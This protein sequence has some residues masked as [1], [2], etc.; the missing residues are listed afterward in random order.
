MSPFIYNQ[1]LDFEAAVSAR[2]QQNLRDLQRES[3]FKRPELREKVL[4]FAQKWGLEPETV[5]SKVQ[6]DWLF[7]LQFV[8]DPIRQT[9]HQRLAAEFIKSNLQ[10]LVAD[11]AELPSGGAAAKWLISGMVM[12][13]ADYKRGGADKQA[14]TVDFEWRLP[15]ETA[16]GRSLRFY[17]SHKFT[18]DEGGTQN[19][20][21]E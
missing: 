3:T 2:R 9:L 8:K 21:Y 6:D 1:R 20:Q 13:Q 15:I 14:R 5:W 19:N 7:A 16:D 11:F 18:K 4:S 10:P 17:A 12:P